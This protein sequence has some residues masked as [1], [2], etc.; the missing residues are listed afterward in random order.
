M[1]F[2][3][4]K[5]DF[6]PDEVTFLRGVYKVVKDPMSNIL[7]YEVPA[8]LKSKLEVLEEAGIVR[9]I[10]EESIKDISSI[11][12]LIGLTERVEMLQGG[13][14]LLRV[15]LRDGHIFT[16]TESQLTKPYAIQK[17]LLRLKKIV[18]VRKDEWVELL[19][20]WFSISEDIE[21]I[22]EDDEIREKVITYLKSCVIYTDK[23][24]S[25]GYRTLLY[26]EKDND[27]VYCYSNNLKRLLGDISLRKIRWILSDYIVGKSLQLR[28]EK[29]NSGLGNRYRFWA[30]G[31][32]KCGIDLEQQLF[33]SE[34]DKT[35]G[36]LME[37][38]EEGGGEVD[39]EDLE[40]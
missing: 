22:S 14:V 31:I 30:F 35:F 26:I 33:K 11:L 28:I 2:V 39:E 6:Y 18:K 4:V 34:E 24:K 3:I 32:E 19:K 38:Q 13:S 17:M 7:V 40:N 37:D 15:T 23:W 9:V 1:R 21:E 20:Y 12:D 5:D 10:K 25:L 8:T 29:E 27:R 16:F 36:E